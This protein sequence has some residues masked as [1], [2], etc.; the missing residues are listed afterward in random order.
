MRVFDWLGRTLL[1][2]MAGLATL[3][4]IASVAS[5]SN[6]HGTSSPS[7]PGSENVAERFEMPETPPIEPGERI[8]SEAPF[9]SADET[10]VLAALSASDAQDGEIARWLESL[11]YAVLALAGFMAAAL[12]VLLRITA[13]LARIAER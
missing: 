1:L 9:A 4:I 12:L 8:A 6:I 11:T 2:V 13:L 5:V 7:R 3:S 10:G